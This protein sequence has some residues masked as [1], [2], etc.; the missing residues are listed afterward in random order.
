MAV[1]NHSAQLLLQAMSEHHVHTNDA[2]LLHLGKMHGECPMSD[3]VFE[4][5]HCSCGDRHIHTLLCDADYNNI[6]II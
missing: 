5:L 3:P 1:G 2:M 4:A 6:I